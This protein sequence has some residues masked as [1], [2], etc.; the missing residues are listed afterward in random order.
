MSYFETPNRPKDAPPVLCGVCGNPLRPL[1]HPTF[2]ALDAAFC[3]ND[4]F[5]HYGPRAMEAA[6]SRFADLE[7]AADAEIGGNAY[8]VGD[9]SACPDCGY[10]GRCTAHKWVARGWMEVYV[11][12]R[13]FGKGIHRALA[14]EGEA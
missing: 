8:R 13:E 2:G 4:E 14:K 10:R 9:E 11:L 5:A 12:G 7:K 1:V 6:R 3:P